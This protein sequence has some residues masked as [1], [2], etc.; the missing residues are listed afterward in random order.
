MLK[1]TDLASLADASEA[2]DDVIDIVGTVVIHTARV[3]LHHN[4]FT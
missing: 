1:G 2:L 3:P 4:N